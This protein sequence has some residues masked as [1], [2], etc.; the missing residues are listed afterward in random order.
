MH[1]VKC[2]PWLGLEGN[3][4][5]FNFANKDQRDSLTTCKEF[6]YG[7]YCVGEGV[8]TVAGAVVD[9]KLYYGVSMCSPKD[10][11]SKKL[12]RDCAEAN[13]VND[14][15]SRL[16]GVYDNLN[17]EESPAEALREAL[18]DFLGRMRQRPHWIKKDDEVKFRGERKPSKQVDKDAMTNKDVE[19]KLK[20]FQKTYPMYKADLEN[21]SFE[22]D[23]S[24]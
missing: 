17:G 23:S 12:G 21:V 4:R 6:T 10:N 19:E 2:I 16:R 24:E 15:K 9:G 13:L 5:D 20:K 22:V 8:V 1:E 3:V 14:H 18:E 11:F 7:H